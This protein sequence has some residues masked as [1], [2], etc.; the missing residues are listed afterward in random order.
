MFLD[1]H[2]V[3][4]KSSITE[5]FTLCTNLETTINKG[6]LNFYS[7]IVLVFDYLLVQAKYFFSDRFRW[8]YTLEMHKL[9]I[10]T[11]QNVLH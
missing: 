4:P 9:L 5:M 6:Y 11:L 3:G 8:L 1:S 2:R 10:L 7:Y